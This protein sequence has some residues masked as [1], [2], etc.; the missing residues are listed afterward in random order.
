ML[1]L[2]PKTKNNLWRPQS[3]QPD[4]NTMSYSWPDTYTT[5][6]THM[7]PWITQTGLIDIS[8]SRWKIVPEHCANNQVWPLL[9]QDLGPTS[10][11]HP[12]WQII[13]LIHIYLQS[14]QFVARAL[15]SGHRVAARCLV[16]ALGRAA[17]PTCTKYHSW[18]TYYWWNVIPDDLVT[19]YLLPGYRKCGDWVSWWTQRRH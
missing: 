6:I 19:N 18:L 16:C 5:H 13:L 8:L 11:Y 7:Y 15:C 17:K 2:L 12:H 14:T 9:A 10:L 4:P 3:L 1:S